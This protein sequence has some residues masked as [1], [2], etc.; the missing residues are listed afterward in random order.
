A[1]ESAANRPPVALAEEDGPQG[2]LVVAAPALPLEPMEGELRVPLQDDGPDSG[3]TVA[4]TE[5]SDAAPAPD[6]ATLV[7][8]LIAEALAEDPGPGA[9][10]EARPRVRPSGHTVRAGPAPRPAAAAPARVAR[11]ESQPASPA[12]VRE[13][14][15]VN[16]GARLVQLGA[17][18]NEAL[19][20]QV[21]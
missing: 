3:T 9:A 12:A 6:I 10:A 18:D 21:W 5:P 11:A 16:P 4:S 15:G 17:F 20:R 14:S 2:E 19:A 1:A 7:P 8:R 13:V